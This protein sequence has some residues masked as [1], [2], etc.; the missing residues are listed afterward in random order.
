VYDKF[1]QYS[2]TKLMNHLATL[3]IHR[4]MFKHKKQ[5]Q[6]TVNVVDA[7]QRVERR[8]TGTAA[9]TRTMASAPTP[10]L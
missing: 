5:F 6:V 1:G 7:E 10:S 8:T 4:L 2:R 3:Y 9:G